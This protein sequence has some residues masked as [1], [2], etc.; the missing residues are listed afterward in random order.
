M[1]PETVTIDRKQIGVPLVRKKTVSR[2]VLAG[3]IVTLLAVATISFR[4]LGSWLIREDR[5]DHADA[6]VVLSG[7]MPARA[8]EAARLFRTGYAPE[9]WISRPG[10]PA[11]E[12]AGLG[13][14]YKGEEAYNREILIHTG[15][16]ESCIHYFPDAIVNTEEE[17]E[18][19]ARGLRSGGKT[20]A[21]IVTSRQHTRRVRTLWSKLAG[22]GLK[23]IVHAAPGDPF[24]VHW[25]RTTRDTFAVLRET[26]GLVNVWAGLPV[27]PR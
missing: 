22:K 13:V 25:W 18:E 3:V 14:S 20:T 12:L 7:S 23:A 4:E 21:I 16:P 19:I 9:V 8:E 15:V 27:R 26:M 24:D 2:I 11:S 6:I 5:L 17:V 10:S 1:R